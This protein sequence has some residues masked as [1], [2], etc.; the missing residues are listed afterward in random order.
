MALAVDTHLRD[1]ETLIG[2]EPLE[3]GRADSTNMRARGE[4]QQEW[5][6]RTLETSVSQFLVVVGHYPIYS[7]S[8]ATQLLRIMT[9]QTVYSGG[10]HGSNQELI[11]KLL[12]LLQKFEVDLYICGTLDSRYFL[13]NY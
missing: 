9:I 13:S 10:E 7:G 8:I 12:P 5:L 3:R 11:Q 2:G 6:S 4:A 1:L